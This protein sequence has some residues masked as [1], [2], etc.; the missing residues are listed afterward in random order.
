MN[1]KCVD[2]YSREIHSKWALTVAALLMSFV[3]HELR[4]EK[5]GIRL[6]QTTQ[7]STCNQKRDLQTA[8]VQMEIETWV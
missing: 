8:Q 2:G 4:K 7:T 3:E 6:V 1:S 5:E